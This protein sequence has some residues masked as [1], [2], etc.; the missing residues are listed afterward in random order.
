MVGFLKR[1]RSLEG[2]RIA[3]AQQLVQQKEARAESDQARGHQSA[4]QGDGVT[5]EQ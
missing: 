5:E 3:F 4:W 2:Y 1:E